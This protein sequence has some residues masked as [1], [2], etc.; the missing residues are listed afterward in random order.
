VV[1][2]ALLA[3]SA[4]TL[5]KQPALSKHH[6]L[7][8]TGT[9]PSTPSPVPRYGLPVSLKIP[10][11]DVDV[12]VRTTGLTATGDMDVPANVLEV[13]WYKYG[14]HPGNQGSAVIGGHLDGIKAE[15]GA[16]LN[17]KR[18]QK[19]DVLSIVDDHGAVILF[20]VRETRIYGQ[21]ERPAEVFNSVDGIHLNLITCTGPWDQAQGRFSERLVVFADMVK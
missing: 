16:F 18:L 7:D 5:F 12:N 20:V 17:L 3:Y 9:Q 10:K 6:A 15:P 14:V 21:K 4:H 11:L 8:A 1:P 19:G 2:V 13:G